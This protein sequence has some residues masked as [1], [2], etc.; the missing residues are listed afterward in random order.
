[1]AQ[2]EKTALRAHLGL[3]RSVTCSASPVT[4]DQHAAH[5]YRL[6]TCL[7][8]Q[9][10]RAGG[11]RFGRRSRQDGGEW[12]RAWIYQNRFVTGL[13]PGSIETLCRQAAAPTGLPGIVLP[14]DGC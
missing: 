13:L 5:P 9:G 6:R 8:G 2:A 14:P 3:P 1:M 7:L 10:Y 11:F 4:A 12:S